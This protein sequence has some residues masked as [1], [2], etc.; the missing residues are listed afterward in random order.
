L[1]ELFKILLMMNAAA[2]TDA[3][4]RERS[5]SLVVACYA[6]FSVATWTQTWTRVSGVSVAGLAQGWTAGRWLE[7][8]RAKQVNLRG[9]EGLH[10]AALNNFSKLGKQDQ[11][12]SDSGVDQLNQRSAIHCHV[13]GLQFES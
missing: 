1:I 3:E 7:G 2:T 9:P 11:Q 10:G 13:S 6:T 12:R 4:C 8:R 5:E